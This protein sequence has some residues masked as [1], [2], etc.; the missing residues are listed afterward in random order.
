[1]L[2]AAE[3]L[4]GLSYCMSCILAMKSN[5]VLGRDNCS[6]ALPLVLCCLLV[7]QPR[8]F[9]K[10]LLLSQCHRLLC[11]GLTM[12]CGCAARQCIM[13]ALAQPASCLWVLS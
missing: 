7:W 13:Q 1:M 2:P 6:R 12:Q 8:A 10:M 5:P 9:P 4:L 11:P 3:V